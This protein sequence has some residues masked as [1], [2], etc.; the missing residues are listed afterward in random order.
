[1]V[2]PVVIKNLT[3]QQVDGFVAKHS[4][5]NVVITPEEGDRFTVQIK[6][7]TPVATTTA[8]QRMV[9]VAISPGGTVSFLPGP[10]ASR[11]LAGIVGLI[12]QGS[13]I[14]SPFQ[15]R[16]DFLATLPGG[17]L[18]FD[19]ELQ[20]DTDGSDVSVGDQFHQDQ[21]SY[22]YADGSSI[23]ANKVPFFVLPQKSQWMTN[24]GI[25]LG[26]IGAVVYEDKL[27][28]AVF[29]DFGPQ[30]KLGE[31]SVELHRRLGFERVKNNKIQDVG[32]GPGVITIVF[33]GSGPSSRLSGQQSLLDYIETNGK[34]LFQKI[35]GQIT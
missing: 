2:D 12:E 17:E 1:M 26:D 22:R 31:G 9:D 34:T 3:K 25:K 15:S 21:T 29:A 28:F 13:V 11:I 8:T 23:N 32:I 19:S 6:F 33:P 14:Q 10:E 16:V 35:G 18:I 7:D 24:L 5:Q 20:L 27:A 4:A 30:T